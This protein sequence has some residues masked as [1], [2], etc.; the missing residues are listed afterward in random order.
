MIRNAFLAVAA[1]F[2]SLSVM[3]SAIGF[4]SL[5]SGAPVA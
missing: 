1:T 3:A 2:C 5:N 4:I